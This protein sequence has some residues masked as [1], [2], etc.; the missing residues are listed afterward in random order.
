MRY[1]ERAIARDSGYAPAH[2]GLALMQAHSG[3]TAAARRSAERAREI[4]PRLADAPLALGMIRQP[5]DLPGAEAALR[6]A[7]Q[8]NPGHAEAH[9]EF[10]MLLLRS[11][12]LADALRE[13]QLTVYLSPL[14]ARFE[15]GLGE[16]HFFS[17]RFDEALI[18]AKQALSHDSAYT[19][20]YLLQAWAYSMQRRFAEAEESL[21]A[22]HAPPCREFERP[23]LGSIKAATGRRTEAPRILD[24]LIAQW[25]AGSRSSD[26]PWRIAEVYVGLGERQR[27]ID[28]LE[29]EDKSGLV[30]LYMRIDPILRPLHSEPRFRALLKARG[31]PPPQ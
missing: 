3:D 17:G 19:A 22:C 8:L 24:T 4:D 23:L 29:Q 21:R 6:Q 26:L 18:A 7:I 1:F 12:R 2:A 11:N 28:W 15:V 25:Q 31:L 9:H 16:V 13:A 5:L 30:I 20:P 14:T 27:A 10:S